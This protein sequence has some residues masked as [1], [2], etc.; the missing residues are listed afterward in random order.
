M[1]TIDLI[2]RSYGLALGLFFWSTLALLGCDA[3]DGRESRR[4]GGTSPTAAAPTSSFDQQ[5]AAVRAGQVTTIR[6][7]ESTL[8]A[9]QLQTLG[10]LIALTQ[11]EL[12]HAAVDD[13]FARQIASLPQLEVLVLGETT[14]GDDGWHRLTSLKKLKRLNVA[15]CEIDDA[16]LRGI[17]SLA[18]LELLRVGSSRVTDVGLAEIAKL[19]NLRHLI[20]RFAP[21]TDA[22][23]KPLA[24]MTRLESLY[25]ERTQVT[26]AGE[27]ELL[28]ARPELHIHFP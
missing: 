5:A 28:R 17:S 24:G 22:G 2:S 4:L 16:A 6:A 13:A 9:A 3:P 7:E 25:L 11:L 12:P 20:I 23:L 14:I 27:R 18:E 15:K 1:M 21:I 26:E 19:P 8:Q 10:T